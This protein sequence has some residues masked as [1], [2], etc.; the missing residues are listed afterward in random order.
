[1]YSQTSTIIQYDV[2]YQ[3]EEY[4]SISVN[5]DYFEIPIN[6]KVI[7]NN[8]MTYVTAGLSIAIPLNSEAINNR[9]GNEEDIKERFE[10]Y[11][12]SANF[13]IGL[14]FYVGKPMMFVELRYSQ[15]L[16]NLIKVKIR[17]ID[18]NNKLKSNSIQLNTGILFTP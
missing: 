14:Q 6:I 9:R 15:S 3:Y 8:E 18:L 7:A 16:T 13:G 2:N 1:M 10:P 12:L 11:V 17:E 4:D 5:T